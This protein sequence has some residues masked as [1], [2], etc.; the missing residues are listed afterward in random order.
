[1]SRRQAV[2]ARGYD[3]EQLDEEIRADNERAASLGLSFAAPSTAP[4]GVAP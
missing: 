1:M 2:A 4:Q 3:L